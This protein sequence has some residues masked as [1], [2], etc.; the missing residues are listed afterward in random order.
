[1]TDQLEEIRN[2][3]NIKQKKIENQYELMK[4][5]ISNTEKKIFAEFERKLRN[6]T[7]IKDFIEDKLA[8]IREEMVKMENYIGF[9]AENHSF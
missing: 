7:V 9:R 5:V 6:E 8:E 2:N 4:T 1:M 3:E